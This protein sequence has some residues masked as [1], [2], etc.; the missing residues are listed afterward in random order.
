M[1]YKLSVMKVLSRKDT[2]HLQNTAILLLEQDQLG[3]FWL[4]VYLKK[5]KNF[6]YSD[7][8][9]NSPFSK[10]KVDNFQGLVF[11]YVIFRD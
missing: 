3:V 8:N 9:Q 10:I 4:I 11:T 2:Q 7:P 5:G 6:K 1:A